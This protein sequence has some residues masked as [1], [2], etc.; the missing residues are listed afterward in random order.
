LYIFSSDDHTETVDIDFDPAQTSYEKLLKMFWNNHDSTSCKSRQYMS[1]IFFHNNEQK[2][3]AEQ[4]LQDHQKAT[5][6]KIQTRI[7]PAE[8]FYEAEK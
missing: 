4:S 8:T 6:K 1:A 5:S 2:K 3:H 7:L